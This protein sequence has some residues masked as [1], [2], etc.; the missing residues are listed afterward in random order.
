MGG[1]TS[2]RREGHAKGGRGKRKETAPR[3]RKKRTGQ[4]RRKKCPT[5]RQIAPKTHGLEKMETPATRLEK[6]RNAL[7]LEM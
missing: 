1:G 7:R 2:P 6:A 5:S 4:S 3:W